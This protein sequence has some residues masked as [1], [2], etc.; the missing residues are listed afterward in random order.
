MSLYS[1]KLFA[2]LCFAVLGLAVAASARKEPEEYSITIT[3]AKERPLATLRDLNDAF[4]DVARAVTPTVVTVSTE[5][6]IRGSDLWSPFGNP[7]FSGPLD[8]PSGEGNDSNRGRN[9]GQGREFRQQGLGSGVIVSRDGYILTNNH[10][11]SEADRI[12]VRTT[13]GR[14]YTAHVVGTDPKSDVA[15]I[16]IDTDGLPAIALGNSDSLRVGEIVMAV[17]SPLTTNLAHTVTQGIVSAKGRSNVGLADYED[18]IQTDAAINPGNSG[19]ALVNLDGQL[20][21]INSAIMS[22]SGGFQGIGF[23]VPVNMAMKIMDAL[24]KDGKVVRGWLGV[25]IQ[26][27]T[28]AIVSAMN[29]NGQDGSLIGDVA[30]ES[31]ASKAG[32]QAGDIITAIGDQKVTNSSQVR[33][34]ISSTAPGSKITLTILRDGRE[35]DFEAQLMELPGEAPTRHVKEVVRN[36][37]GFTVAPLSRELAN[38]HG[39]D[40]NGTGLVVTEI[41]QSSNAY[42]SG[43]REGDLIRTVNQG[44]VGLASDLNELLRGAQKGSNVLLQIVR[45]DRGFFIA[46]SL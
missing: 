9:R 43:L 29:L 28:E 30:P 11:I 36:L 34:E 4:V 46:F 12:V 3:P 35:R 8:D 41:D 39:L 45:R 38:K 37:L 27:L 25:S 13:S 31:P 44:K 15:V 7:F 16:K 18:Y 1:R 19:G 6:V 5:K 40:A 23:A 26:D 33:N 32:L 24:M 21:G 42:S 10:V 22:Q 17:G 14:R 2:L 20:V